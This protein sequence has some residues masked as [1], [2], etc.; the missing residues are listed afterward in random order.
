MIN[1]EIV[2]IESRYLYV[3]LTLKTIKEE[4]KEQLNR[5]IKFYYL[6]ENN[7]LPLDSTSFYTK[8]LPDTITYE[9]SLLVNGQLI[10]FNIEDPL[11]RK[12]IKTRII[13]IDE[14]SLSIKYKSEPILLKT[15]EVSSLQFDIK[16]FY[17]GKFKSKITLNMSELEEESI[18]KEY[19]LEQKIETHGINVGRLSTKTN[20]LLSNREFLIEHDGVKEYGSYKITTSILNTKNQVIL[21]NVA[22]YSKQIEPLD[23]VCKMDLPSKDNFIARK[24]IK[25][26]A[27]KTQTSFPRVTKIKINT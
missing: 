13:A 14:T 16:N 18:V 6:F 21:A 17:D 25:I 2:S 12:G 26:V 4:D 7:L 15:K 9:D 10:R 1:F 20:V 3:K 11:L 19:R 5:R 23:V 27:K 8:Y 22:Y 24:P